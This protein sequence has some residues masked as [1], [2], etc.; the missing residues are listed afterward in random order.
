MEKETNIGN[1]LYGDVAKPIKTKE[2]NHSEELRTGGKNHH[3]GPS[4][5]GVRGSRFDSSSCKHGQIEGLCE[6]CSETSGSTKSRV[7][8]V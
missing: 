2:F 5:Q 8:S 4:L 1:H 3:N 7:T 6:H